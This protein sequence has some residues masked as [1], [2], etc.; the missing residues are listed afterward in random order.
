MKMRTYLNYT[1]YNIQKLKENKQ[2][3]RYTYTG[4]FDNETIIIGSYPTPESAFKALN[5]AHE[6]GVTDIEEHTFYKLCREN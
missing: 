3:Y 4:V 2:L 6:I 1:R 5:I